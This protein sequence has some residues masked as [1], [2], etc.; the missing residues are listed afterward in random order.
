ME[1]F[2]SGRLFLS[3]NHFNCFEGENFDIGGKYLQLFV[4]AWGFEFVSS[5]RGFETALPPQ[6][7]T[8]VRRAQIRRSKNSYSFI[9]TD[10]RYG[11]NGC[12]QTDHEFSGLRLIT[13]ACP[14][15]RTW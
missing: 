14:Y 5:R 10:M 12:E 9:S 11:E 8:R 3:G 1:C 2:G 4:V 15:L 13:E 6:L 7:S